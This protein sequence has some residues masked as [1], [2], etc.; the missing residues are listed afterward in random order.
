MLMSHGAT[1]GLLA[2]ALWLSEGRQTLG[3]PDARVPSFTLLSFLRTKPPAIH[4]LL[5]ACTGL[6]CGLAVAGEYTALPAAAV[7]MLL[8][9]RRSAWSLLFVVV[10]VLLPL[11]LVSFYNYNAFHSVL[12]VGYSHLKS[13]KGMDQGFFGITLFPRFDVVV[14]L[15]FSEYR[16]FLFWTPFLLLAVPGFA[17]LHQKDNLLFWPV[18]GV[19]ILYVLLISTY[20]Y[21]DG[22][23]ALSV[24]HFASLLPFLGLAAGCGMLRYPRTGIALAGA[25]VLLTGGATLIDAMPP[26]GCTHPIGD[27]FLRKLERGDFAHNLGMEAGLRGY[28]S[29]MPLLVIVAAGVVSLYLYC[30]AADAKLTKSKD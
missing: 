5:D 28:W 18:V 15:L 6:A 29:L 14:R 4:F 17:V 11:F 3:L 12:S 30:A 22:G 20:P 26:E 8:G 25:S 27:H 21:W 10:G 23:W 2:I 1:F 19:P 13:F 16:G 7:I 24:R 9:A